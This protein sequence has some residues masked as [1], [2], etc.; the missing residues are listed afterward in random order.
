M[1][2]KEVVFYPIFE[3]SVLHILLDNRNE[4]LPRFIM[5]G[6]MLRVSMAHQHYSF[7]VPWRSPGQYRIHD[8]QRTVRTAVW[9]TCKPLVEPRFRP[10]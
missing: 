3:P 6:F 10:S 2:A 4:P 9:T 1:A 5:I 7:E 8:R